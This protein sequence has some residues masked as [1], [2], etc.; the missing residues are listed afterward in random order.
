VLYSALGPADCNGTNL[1]DELGKQ[2]GILLRDILLQSGVKRAVIAGGDT[3]SHAG[4]Q[5]G[6]YALTMISD[7]TPGAPL[8]R[9]HSDEKAFSGLEIVMKGGQMGREDFFGS[10]L[11]GRL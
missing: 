4:Q 7:L 5:L 8:C 3:S 6:T 10:A 11:R 1:R 2:V 9:A